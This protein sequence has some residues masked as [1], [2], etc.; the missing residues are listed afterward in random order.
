MAEHKQFLFENTEVV[1]SEGP[2]RDGQKAG[3]WTYYHPNGQKRA[4][5][6][7]DGSVSRGE[8]RYWDE[9]GHLTA[10][11]H[12]E[13]NQRHGEWR[14]FHSDG[15]LREEACY[16]QGA[17]H[18]PRRCYFNDGSLARE[19]RYE[20]GLLEGPMRA[21]KPDGAVAAEG[22]YQA[23]LLEGEYKALDDKGK[24]K[25]YKFARGVIQLTEK[26]RQS[27][28]KQMRSKSSSYAKLKVVEKACPVWQARH[29][30]LW[31]LVAKGDYDAG[32]DPELWYELAQNLFGVTAAEVVALLRS[33]QELPEGHGYLPG[34]PAALDRIVCT[35]Y[36]R[37]PE[38]LDAALESFSAP[39][40]HGLKLVLRRFGKLGRDAFDP[41]EMARQLAKT[42]IEHYG[43]GTLT[44]NGSFILWP[45]RAGLEEHPVGAHSDRPPERVFDELIELFTTREHWRKAC[46][47]V[48]LARDY[49][50]SPWKAA[51]AWR[52]ASTPDELFHLIRTLGSP[53][54][55]L[56]RVL[57]TLR[58]DDDPATWLPVA[59]RLAAADFSG[60]ITADRL[61]CAA[62]LKLHRQGKPVDEELLR[63]FQFDGFEYGYG[64]GYGEMFEG[65][66]VVRA[67]LALFPKPTARRLIEQTLTQEYPNDHALPFLDEHLDDEMWALVQAY[68][69]KQ[70]ERNDLVLSQWLLMGRGFGRME[71]METALLERLETSAEATEGQVRDLFR[72]CGLHV[73][74]GMARR[75]QRWDSR[76]DG[77]LDFHL[78]S[79][80]DDYDYVHYVQPTLREALAGLPP[81]RAES[82]WRASLRPDARF[83]ARPFGA[84]DVVFSPAVAEEA[85][86]FLAAHHAAFKMPY[87]NTVGDGLRGL[88]ERAR[89]LVEAL[90]RHEG[91]S[92]TVVG[93]LKGAL[94]ADQVDAWIAAAQPAGGSAPL[95]E[96]APHEKLARLSQA[97]FE[98]YGASRARETI[99][100]LTRQDEAPAGLSKVG[101]LPV[102]V[103]RK[104]WPKRRGKT[105]MTHL[106]TLD[107]AE[108]PK[109][110]AR[111][112]DGSA[113]LLQLFVEDPDDNEAYSPYNEQTRV[114][115]VG[116]E[117]LEAG[118]PEGDWVDELEAQEARGVAIH[119]VEVPSGAFSVG[120]DDEGDEAVALRDIRSAIYRTS[121]RALGE[122]LWLQG[123][124]EGGGF[125]LQFDEG[126]ADVN[127]GDCGV[128]Y[129]FDDTAFW[130]CH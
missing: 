108:L 16:E 88:G 46:L 56:Y 94:N 61:M 14:W 80:K 130:Q 114:V 48:A 6:T 19:E 70:L 77:F 123:E 55:Q 2:W 117:A 81:E 33:I 53:K 103:T 93:W 112:G 60:R 23:G 91:L 9:Q 30:L 120:Y 87:H 73:L 124:E 86:R 41:A 1:E 125:L 65:E 74:A 49:D 7:E 17:L 92:G 15:A 64:S 76:W 36:Q 3:V 35:V 31:D 32:S 62:M 102:G 90:A 34:W 5:G 109:L 100:L 13:D 52:A 82:V 54:I 29:R 24:V 51:E 72:W 96:E 101:G 78:V 10:V 95:T 127:L 43:L 107:L 27:L 25:T 97:Y 21:F 122:P 4:E 40:Q 22:S 38:A 59:D 44:S 106:W 39:V 47:E 129:V 89:L 67:V 58:P 99:Y 116:E 68:V 57:D 8:W 28:A 121:C 18:G 50:T 126:F 45:E 128:M 83:A 85:A 111:L 98:A 11:G 119:E 113:R 63:H 105:P 20:R 84:I 69:E 110:R 118:E 71:G 75:G 115:L 79:H 37:E 42:H 66:E 26:R 12:F 104:S